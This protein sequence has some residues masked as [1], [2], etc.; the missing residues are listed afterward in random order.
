MEKCYVCGRLGKNQLYIGNGYYR[1]RGHYPGS[2]MWLK[3]M[4]H[5]EIWGI[6]AGNGSN[7][8]TFGFK[9]V[10]NIFKKAKI[11]GVKNE[12]G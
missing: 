1:C 3:R 10:V 9:P 7:R 6:F 4:R 5:R 11:K 12:V 8:K 2:S